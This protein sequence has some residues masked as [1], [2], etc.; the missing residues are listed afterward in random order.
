MS[1]HIHKIFIATLCFLVFSTMQTLGQSSNAAFLSQL[2]LNQAL[3]PAQ[4]IL[5]TK[6]LVLISAPVEAAPGEWKN[7]ATEMQTYFGEVGIDAMAYFNSNRQFTTPDFNSD[8]PKLI[9]D[10]KVT[11]LIF[12]I[13]GVENQESII[14]IGPYNGKPTL[15]DQSA[16][17]WS[18][19]F[20]KI[21][22]VFE[23]MTLRFKTGAFKRSNLLVN[24]APEFFDFTEPSYGAN[25]A[26]FPPE[27]K[28]KLLGIP[29][30]KVES[31]KAG[32]H[33]LIADD[34][35]NPEKPAQ[36]VQNRNNAL[37]AVVVDSLMNMQRIDLSTRTEALLRRDG[38]THIL[39]YVEGDSEYLYDLFR[40][41]GR[42]EVQ[43]SYLV[44]FFLKDLRNKNVFLGRSWDASTD[45]Q[46]ALNSF[47]AQIEQELTKQAN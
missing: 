9:K 2:K 38:I 10:R 11:N 16:V 33:L 20:T 31:D 36:L 47:M 34:F 7:L 42:E 45:W 5:S 26:S 44:K 35:R 37:Q 43:A 6:S 15:Y 8:I 21:E 40:F 13:M 27:L 28:K 24:D 39:Y 18:R 30:L 29:T 1:T 4:D 14:G 41:K 25:Y 19:N 12:V 46:E 22:S 32:S 23:E 3:D 17:F